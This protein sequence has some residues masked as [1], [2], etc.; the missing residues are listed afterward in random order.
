[1]QPEETTVVDL[2]ITIQDWILEVRWAWLRQTHQMSLDDYQHVY[3]LLM[4][5]LPDQIMHHAFVA[6]AATRNSSSREFW[7]A[8]REP[9]RADAERMLELAAIED[10][11]RRVTFTE[12]LEL[13]DSETLTEENTEAV[14]DWQA[15]D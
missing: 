4:D 6:A 7:E 8:M 11:M 14:I 2:L 15:P 9:V 5:E 3:P 10:S 12:F 1:M 13:L